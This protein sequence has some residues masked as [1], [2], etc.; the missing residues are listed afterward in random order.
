MPRYVK[1][2]LQQRTQASKES[3]LGRG[4]IV[5]EEVL[6]IRDKDAYVGGAIEMAGRGKW[7]VVSLISEEEE[8]RRG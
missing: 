8:R 4:D 7:R 3:V 2:R 1:A 5:S 6:W